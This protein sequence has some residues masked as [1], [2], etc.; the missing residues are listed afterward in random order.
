MHLS[1]QGF[2]VCHPLYSERRYSR[3]LKRLENVERPL[4]PGYVLVELDLET[5]GWQRVRGTRGLD[6]E[7]LIKMAGTDQ[8]A[9]LPPLAMREI[10]LK[11]P[12]VKP[13]EDK[14]LSRDQFMF[15][16]RRYAIKE[17]GWLE[18]FRPGVRVRVTEGPFAGHEAPVEMTDKERVWVLLSLFG[19]QRRVE[20]RAD[21][22]ELAA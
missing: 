12:A 11:S 6:G 20:H 7:A 18:S 4:F 2:T 13:P 16:F 14:K 10:L 5:E 21:Q 9:P 3:R 19:T 1:D 17:L 15:R 22:L 8:P